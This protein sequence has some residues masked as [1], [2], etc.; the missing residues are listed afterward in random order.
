MTLATTSAD[1]RRAK[2]H[3]RCRRGMRE[4]DIVLEHFLRED[5]DALSKTE[6]A[7]FERL[8]DQT[9]PDLVHWLTGQSEAPD[10]G[11]T[12]LVKR[13]SRILSSE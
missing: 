11:L 13:L 7:D 3:W 10:A 2:L 8:L 4:L 6:Q 5:F 9:D 1:T 12:R